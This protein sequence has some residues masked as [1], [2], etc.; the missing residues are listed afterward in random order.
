MKLTNGDSIS[1]PLQKYANR[2]L[3]EKDIQQSLDGLTHVKPT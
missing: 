2:L 1:L 3:E